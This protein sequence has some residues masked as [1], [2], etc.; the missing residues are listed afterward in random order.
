VKIF[1]LLINFVLFLFPAAKGIYANCPVCVVTVGGGL[2]M[3]IF[4]VSVKL[5]KLIRQKNHNKVL[6]YYQKVII[7]LTFLLLVTFFIYQLI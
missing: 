6:F 4:F 7:P 3:L 1:F 5:D 2:G